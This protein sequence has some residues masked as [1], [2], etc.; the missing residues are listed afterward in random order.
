PPKILELGNAV[1][2]HHWC[3]PFSVDGNPTPNISWLYNG[4]ELQES[5][6]IFTQVIRDESDGSKTHGCL[7]FNKPTHLN[8]GNYTL[9]VNNSLGGAAATACGMFM[10]NPFDNPE[11]LIPG[12]RG[13]ASVCIAVG[14]THTVLK[15][16][17]ILEAIGQLLL[18]L[19]AGLTDS[20]TAT[21][22]LTTAAALKGHENLGTDF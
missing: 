22:I 10:D 3:F 19:E 5:M 7:A 15:G 18:S 2:Q 9:V 8:N 20:Q 21:S 16:I 14:L 11:G 17:G 12:N 13:D 6:Y 4:S 1:P